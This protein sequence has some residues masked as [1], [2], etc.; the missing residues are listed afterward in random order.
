MLTP[1]E[2]SR[3]QNSIDNYIYTNCKLWLILEVMGNYP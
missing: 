2:S 3:T 1:T